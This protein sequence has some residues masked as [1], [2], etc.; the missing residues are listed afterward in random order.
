MGAIGTNGRINDATKIY[1]NQVY[2]WSIVDLWRELPKLELIF[3]I[4]VVD[5]RN[6]DTIYLSNMLELCY[7]LGND[8][9]W[10]VGRHPMGNY[11]RIQQLDNWVIWDQEHCLQQNMYQL[12]FE[13]V[14]RISF[15]TKTKNTRLKKDEN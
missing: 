15:T 8:N 5:N 9:N 11:Y 12:Y 2:N 13:N 10:H 3:W 1:V 7:S 6:D 4:I 14:H